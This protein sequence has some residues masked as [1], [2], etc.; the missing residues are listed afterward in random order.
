MCTVNHLR[1]KLDRIIRRVNKGLR[2]AVLDENT[3]HF[4]INSFCAVLYITSRSNVY[5]RSRFLALF[6]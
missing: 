2:V 5:F 3:F 6:F 4:G 1:L